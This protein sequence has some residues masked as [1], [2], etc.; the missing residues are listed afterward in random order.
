M[1]IPNLQYNEGIWQL[2]VKDKPFTMLAG[3][4]HNSSASNPKYME[5]NVW[6]HLREMGLNSVLV[7]VYW[8]MIEPIEGKFDFSVISQIIDQARI[9]GL[10]LGILWFGLWKNGLSSY[11][12]SWVKTDPTRF[13]RAKD[14]F[15]KSLDVISPF[16]QEGI[17]A[18][19]KAFAELMSFLK[20]KDEF[21]NTVIIV[22]VENEVGLLGSDRDYSKKANEKYALNIPEALAK[23]YNISGNWHEVFEKEANEIFMEYAYAKAIESIAKSGKNVYPLPMLTNA[24]IEKYPWRPG[25]YPSGGPIARY[26]ELWK[27]IAPSI[28]ILA[29]DV[30]VTDFVGTCEEY[31]AQNNPLIIPEHRRDIRHISNVFYAFGKYNAIGFSPFGI[32]DFMV[33]ESKRKGIGNPQ[34]MKVLNFDSSSWECDKSGQFL[35]DSYKI[36]GEIM[37]LLRTY[38]SQNKVHSFI[39]ENE[40]QKGVIIHMDK[41]DL[42]IDFMDFEES[43]PKSSGIIMEIGTNELLVLGTNFKYSFISRS[44]H[45]NIGIL[46]YSEGEMIDDHYEV[47]RIL[48]GDERYFMIIMEKPQLQKVSW[49]E[50]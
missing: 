9:E 33:E 21:E 10:K 41:C 14:M 20:E 45:I 50:Y 47:E 4:V 30:Y 22:Q 34:L 44:A 46:E 18:D 37:P 35:K 7:P 6:P 28:D 1:N 12:P 29:P 42:Q 2:I 43:T 39:R 36:L 32:E 25:T 26:M 17:E 8:E 13:F 11:V 5:E 23:K 15:G 40:H 19:S 3:E 48:N 38:S 24:W 31:T 27:M 16:C 49:Y